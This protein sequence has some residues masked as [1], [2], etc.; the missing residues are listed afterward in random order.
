MDEHPR[1]RLARLFGLALA[2]H[3]GGDH[4]PEF[5]KPGMQPNKAGLWTI[6]RFSTDPAIN[7]NASLFPWAGDDVNHDDR[8]A[9]PPLYR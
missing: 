7:L 4:R 9:V 8:C 6:Y 2:Y 3:R 5:L 1:A